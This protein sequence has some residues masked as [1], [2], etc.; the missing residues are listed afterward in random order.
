[1]ALCKQV[2][3]RLN[4]SRRPAQQGHPSAR[5]H[6][7]E[8]ERGGPQRRLKPKLTRADAGVLHPLHGEPRGNAATH[9]HKAKGT[10]S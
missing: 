10:G 7:H 9:H 2:F 4:A 5:R 8:R 1:M 6:E 3:A